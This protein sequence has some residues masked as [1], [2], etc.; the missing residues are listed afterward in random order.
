MESGEH[1][2]Q[3]HM[4]TTS[5]VASVSSLIIQLNEWCLHDIHAA[6][7]TAQLVASQ[8]NCLPM[9]ALNYNA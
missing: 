3:D 4:L 8:D 1:V 6:P 5:L 2:H 7:T 9:F